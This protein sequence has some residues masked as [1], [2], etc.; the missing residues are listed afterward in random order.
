MPA[1]ESDPVFVDVLTDE[2][3]SVVARPGAMPVM[4]FLDDLAEADRETARRS[5]YR[6]L[7]ARGVVEPPTPEAVATATALRDGSVELMVRQDVRS[8]VALREAAQVVVPSR[9]PPRP[10]RT[11]GTP[12]SSTTSSSSRRSAGT[13]CTGSRWR[14][15]PRSRR[16]RSARPSTPMRATATGRRSRSRRRRVIRPRPTPSWSGWARPSCAPTSWFAVPE[17]TSRRCSRCCRAPTGA[18][19]S[20]P[21]PSRWWPSH[22]LPRPPG[23]GW[24]TRCPRSGPRR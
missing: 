3:L 1:P 20:R 4:P 9:G 21:A 2:E 12:T 13:G 15:T 23:G 7:V 19:A 24:A 16:W 17:T 18:G 10:P 8:V 5:A 22:W 11:S 14:R 6:S